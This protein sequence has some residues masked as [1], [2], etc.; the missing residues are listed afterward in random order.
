MVILCLWVQKVY[1]ILPIEVN[2]DRIYLE[3]L[4]FYNLM[5]VIRA[6]IIAVRYGF[7]SSFRLNMLTRKKLEFGYL[8]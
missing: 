1:K 7:A 4:F 6:F 3:Q 5:V 2:L 8:C